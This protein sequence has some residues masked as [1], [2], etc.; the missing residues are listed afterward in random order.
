MVK[1]YSYMEWSFFGMM[2]KLNTV[3]LIGSI[4]I[5]KGPGQM[6]KLLD[7]EMRDDI[8]SRLTEEQKDYVTNKVKRGYRTIFANEMAKMKGNVI[9]PDASFEEIE[10]LVEDW[11]LVDY[12]DHIDLLGR[13]EC[14]RPLRYEYVV[15]HIPTDNVLSFGET[16]FEQHTQIDGRIVKA[17][18]K[19]FDKINLERD[20]LLGKI[21]DDWSLYNHLAI[22]PSDLEEAFDGLPEDIRECLHLQLPLLDRQLS[23]LRRIVSERRERRTD[24]VFSPEQAVGNREHVPIVDS[25]LETTEEYQQLSLL[26]QEVDYEQTSLFDQETNLPTEAHYANDNSTLSMGLKRNIDQLLKLGFD[27]ARLICE[28]L[29][30]DQLI[31]SERYITGKPAIYPYVCLYLDFLVSVGELQFVSGDIHNRKYQSNKQN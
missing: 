28:K 15:K 8:L 11:I 12:I 23:K 1:D 17:V 25:M 27:N 26:D 16:H 5:M 31:K 14:G 10:K 30:R 19:G 4:K 24:E 18:L 20:E 7:T 3:H 21:A 6:I 22:S 9:Y 29:I 2:V 13:C